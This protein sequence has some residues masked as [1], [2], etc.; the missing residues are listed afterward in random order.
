MNIPDKVKF[1]AQ[2][3]CELSLLR[4][5]P[6]LNYVP[7]Q[8]AAAAISLAFYTIGSSIWSKKMRKTFGYDIEDL[9]EVIVHLNE[10]HHEAESL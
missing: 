5:I 8:S 6:F 2:Y 7:S 3:L 10:I 9:K 1:L 4:A